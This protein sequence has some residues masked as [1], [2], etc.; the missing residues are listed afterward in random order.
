MIIAVVKDA[1]IGSYGVPIFFANAAVAVRAFSAECNR[2]APDNP[3]FA[4]R[5]DYDLIKIGEYYESSGT[6]ISCDPVVLVH[7]RDVAR[8][9]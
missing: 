2:A 3:V 6:I 9:E 5:G 8:A 7:G 4:N 1:L